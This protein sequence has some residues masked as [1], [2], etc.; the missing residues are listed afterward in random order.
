VRERGGRLRFP[1]EAHEPFAVRRELR[2]QHLDR[3]VTAKPCV[4][5]PIDL[6]HPSRSDLRENLIRPETITKREAHS[7]TSYF[8]S[9]AWNL[10]SDRSGSHRGS[11]R[12]VCTVISPLVTSR[13]SS[14]AIA[15]PRIPTIV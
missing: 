8:A 5:G 1:L 12:R 14:V 7:L 13:S 6:S 2:R 15:C 10:G 11:S 9:S 4:A 3:D